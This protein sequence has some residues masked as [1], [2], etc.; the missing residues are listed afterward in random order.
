MLERYRSDPATLE[1]L[2]NEPLGPYLDSY[3]ASL[4]S[5]GYARSTVRSQMGLLS[6]LSRLLAQKKFTIC[7]LNE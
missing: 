7:D 1:R 5:D 4:E 2:R 3:L 6:H